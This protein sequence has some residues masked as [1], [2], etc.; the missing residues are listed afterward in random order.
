M[1]HLSTSVKWISKKKLN[2]DL[3]FFSNHTCTLLYHSIGCVLMMGDVEQVEFFF[4]CCWS[5]IGE[6]ILVDFSFCLF[7]GVCVPFSHAHYCYYP[8]IPEWLTDRLQNTQTH[9][10]KDKTNNKIQIWIRE[11]N[12]K[13]TFA[14]NLVTAMRESH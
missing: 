7:V 13:K 9:T 8:N 12:E 1:T 14:T 5:N 10:H 11:W 3:T 2:Y 4:C 6:S